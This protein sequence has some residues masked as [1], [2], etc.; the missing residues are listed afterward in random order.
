MTIPRR[1]FIKSAALVGVGGVALAGA[2]ARVA[3]AQVGQPAK[4]GGSVA[5][6]KPPLAVANHFQQATEA[7]NQVLRSGGSSLDAVEKGVNLVERDPEITSVGIGGMPNWEGVLELDASIMHGPTHT[8]G[9]VAAL[10]DIETP[11]SV[12][13]KVME[14]TEHVLLVGQGAQDFALAAGFE[15]KELVPEET[16]NRWQGWKEWRQQE[17][18]HEALQDSVVQLMEE[19]PQHAAATFRAF[20]QRAGDKKAAVLVFEGMSKEGSA[21]L[22]EQLEVQEVAALTRTILGMKVDWVPLPRRNAL[23][24]SFIHALTGTEGGHDTV[25]LIAMDANAELRTCRSN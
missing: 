4:G 2:R 20:Q 24:R 6:A 15:K 1:A 7:A 5:S 14:E 23:L 8:C 10:Q 12:A 22:V 16:R 13:R 11:I 3:Q 9:A 17:K 25:G 18:G 19:D 21:L